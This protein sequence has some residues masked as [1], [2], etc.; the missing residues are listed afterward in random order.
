MCMPGL[1]R[2]G[3]RSQ[4][5]SPREQAG[6]GQRADREMRGALGARSDAAQ[7]AAASGGWM[8]LG[9][10]QDEDPE[11][12]FPV[13]SRGPAF[14]QV[15]AAKAVCGRCAVSL[16]CFAFAVRTGQEDGIWG[17]TTGEERRAMGR[18]AIR[19]TPVLPAQVPAIP[20]SGQVSPLA[21]VLSILTG[22]SR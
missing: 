15:E 4:L 1:R 16:E 22:E 2:E 10:C 7:Y 9:A 19:S 14:S 21:V 11:L 5:S 20:A 3:R 13:G 17:G 18:E 8:L 12:F 6:A